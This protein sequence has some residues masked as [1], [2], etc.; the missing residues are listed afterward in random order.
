ML[1]F[2]GVMFTAC[3]KNQPGGTATQAL[4][5]EWYVMVDAVNDS[6]VP[7]EGGEDFFGIGRIHVNTYNTVANIPTEMWVDDMTNFWEFKSVVNSDVEALTFSAENAANAYYDC[8]VTIEGGRVIPRG[9]INPH[10]TPADSII[11]YVKFSDDDYP[12]TYGHSKYRISGLRYT[13]FESDN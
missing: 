10:G 2:A 8:N 11:F 4:A 5:G 1:M 3:E 12:A 9:T 6:G 13:G 7:I